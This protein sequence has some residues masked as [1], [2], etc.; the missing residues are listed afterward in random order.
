MSIAVP[1][2]L[3]LLNYLALF[4]MIFLIPSLTKDA[5]NHYA[6]YCDKVFVLEENA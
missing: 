1:A 3:S 4:P 5:E 6:Q 2:T